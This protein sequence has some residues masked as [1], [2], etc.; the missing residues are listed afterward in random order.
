MK[1]LSK[2]KLR[3]QRQE[4]FYKKYG[5][6]PLSVLKERSKDMRK[7]VVGT[8]YVFL[9][10]LKSAGLRFI[11]QEVIGFYIVDFVIPSKFLIIELDGYQ[12]IDNK[13]YDQRRDNYLKS[14][15]FSMLRI[16]NKDSYTFDMNY[17]LSIVDCIDYNT[18][19]NKYYSIISRANNEILNTFNKRRREEKL[20][21][22]LLE[23][24]RKGCFCSSADF[25]IPLDNLRISSL[26]TPDNPAD[27]IKMYF[28]NEWLCFLN[29]LN[30]FVRV[31]L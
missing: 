7:I 28:S 26:L 20:K 1:K 5:L 13:E 24:E 23:S 3:Q 14:K 16:S 22:S 4:K 9:N 18:E 2:R 27:V 6:T 8:E 11:H 19:Y 25:I 30:S 21:K 17:I 10:K 15:G 29:D 12:H 31:D